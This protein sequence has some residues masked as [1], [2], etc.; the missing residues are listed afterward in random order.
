MAIDSKAFLEAIKELEESKGIDRTVIASALED[1]MARGVRKQIGRDDALVRS[2][3]DLNDGTLTL[4]QI[5]MIVPDRSDE[6]FDEDLE[7]TTEEAEAID[8]QKHFPGEEFFI[9]ADVETMSKSIILSIKSVLKQRFSEAEKAVVYDA[10]KDKVNT[11]VTGK[12]DRVEDRGLSV[13]IGR[14][15]VYLR[16]K[17][18]IGDE[19]FLPNES[20][21]LYVS[22]VEKSAKGSRIQVSRASSDF[23]RCIFTEDIHEVYDGTIEIK[24]IAREAGERSKVAVYS[25]DP[26]V[27]PAGACIG[28]NGV[29]IQKIVSQLGNG[30]NKEKIDIITY[31]DV[32]GL[33]ICEALKPA[34]VVGVYVDPDENYA[35]A[36]VK[37][38]SYSLAIGKRGVNVRLAAKLTG[39]KIDI[40][41]ESEALDAQLE[42]V[43]LEALQ[44]QDAEYRALKAR[45]ATSNKEKEVISVL[46]GLPEGYVAPQERTYEDN[47]EVTDL[48]EA[49]LEAS[50]NEEV[51]APTVEE[52]EVEVAPVVEETK[53]EPVVEEHQEVV[54]T[55]SLEDL[56]KS[57][58]E[59]NKKKA[60]KT[61]RKSF[62][63]K[64]KEEE[65]E[66]SA[67][68]IVSTGPR[69]SI[70]T[71]EEL[72]EL[73]EEEKEFDGDYEEEDL[74]YEDYDNYYDEK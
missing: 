8:H 72:R 5:K 18:M 20:I 24:G 28:Q 15:S 53:K 68:A 60:Q 73:E 47:D 38:D 64:R 39:Y 41:T 12:V 45:T 36:V 59:E 51:A 16:R 55:T 9:P 58:D 63:N 32:V 54:T 37:D 30:A 10:F 67:S 25:S 34:H 27:D 74:D 22:E 7:I 35:I 48:D 43:S 13:S 49:L 62:K 50:E 46:P 21:R 23:L 4:G 40:D 14:T 52:V 2:T 29:R 56:E 57:L 17:D 31:S 65:E 6:D 11:L 3:I 44:S 1:A 70:Y 66:D 19:K 42:Y 61:T 33:F 69:M 26:N 71:E